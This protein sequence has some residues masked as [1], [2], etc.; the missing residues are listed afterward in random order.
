MK[1]LLAV[2]ILMLGTGVSYG[3]EN[4]N[5]EPA[6]CNQKA[7]GKT[8]AERRRIIGA[9]IRENAR[10][11]NV[12]PMLGKLTECNDKAGNMTGTARSTFV[13]KCMTQ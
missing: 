10:A 9:C 3:R 13:D 2:L 4:K 7:E 5:K 11:D 8:G 1:A 12:P 6:D